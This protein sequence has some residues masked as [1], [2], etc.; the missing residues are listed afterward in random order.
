MDFLENK[1]IYWETDNLYSKI[2]S[3]IV[4]QEYPLISQDYIATYYDTKFIQ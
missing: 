1:E 3:I 2:D 4:R